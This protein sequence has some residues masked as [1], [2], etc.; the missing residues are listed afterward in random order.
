MSGLPVSGGAV[1]VVENGQTSCEMRVPEA[2]GDEEG[3]TDRNISNKWGPTRAVV[4][5][6]ET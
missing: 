2:K 3:M 4:G 1:C 6:R 5:F